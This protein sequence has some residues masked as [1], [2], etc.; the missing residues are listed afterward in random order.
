MGLGSSSSPGVCS[1]D[2]ETYPPKL[3]YVGEHTI[4]RPSGY[5]VAS[6]GIDKVS[7]LAIGDP[8]EVSVVDRQLHEIPLALTQRY[9]V[10]IEQNRT[11]RTRYD[12]V[13]LPRVPV[14][15]AMLAWKPSRIVTALPASMPLSSA[16]WVS[17]S[18]AVGDTERRI[19]GPYPNWRWGGR[20]T[21]A[22]LTTTPPCA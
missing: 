5:V 13:P 10:E 19:K 6:I 15:H 20:R 3:L 11:G 18:P 16:A 9:F 22:V 2:R 12:K 4:A 7:I 17:I 21:V 1:T 14:N 8:P